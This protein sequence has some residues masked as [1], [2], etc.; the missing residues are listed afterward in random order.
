MNHTT[1]KTSRSG[2]PSTYLPSGYVKKAIENEQKKIWIFPW[3][4]VIF[5]SYVSLPEG[6]CRY[7][8]KWPNWMQSPAGP[9]KTHRPGGVSMAALEKMGAAPAG[10]QGTLEGFHRWGVSQ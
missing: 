2:P 7:R 9:W 8:T 6:K 1:S 4:M 10:A 3:K 5:H